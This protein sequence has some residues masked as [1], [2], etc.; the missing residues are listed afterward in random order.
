MTFHKIP[1]NS[2]YCSLW[3]IHL[4]RLRGVEAGVE[5]SKN[6]PSTGPKD[7]CNAVECRSQVWDIHQ[8]QKT[9]HAI[10]EAKHLLVEVLSVGLHILN[11]AWVRFLMAACDGK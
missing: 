11:P 3:S 4:P 8:R 9:Y 1:A 2:A 7:T 6:K 5:D 10:E